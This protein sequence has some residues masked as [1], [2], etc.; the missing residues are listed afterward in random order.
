[1]LQASI[2]SKFPYFI[3]R[4]NDHKS[5]N[6]TNAFLYLENSS[7]SYTNL[8][9]K[10]M[11]KKLCCQ[12]YPIFAGM[13]SIRGTTGESSFPQMIKPISFS[14]LLKYLVFS[15]SCCTRALPR[16]ELKVKLNSMVLSHIHNCNTR[17]QTKVRDIDVLFVLMEALKINANWDLQFLLFHV[18]KINHA[19]S[20]KSEWTRKGTIISPTTAQFSHIRFS[21]NQEVPG[22]KRQLPSFKQDLKFYQNSLVTAS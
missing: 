15:A 6:Q 13:Y 10:K 1:M 5:K 16:K 8:A 4:S 18:T 12:T 2:F 9:L 17:P 19:F 22:K 11:G 14:R 3:R 7:Y 20:N 21:F